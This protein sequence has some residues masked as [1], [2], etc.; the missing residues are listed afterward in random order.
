MDQIKIRVLTVN[1]VHPRR[2][3]YALLIVRRKKTVELWKQST[4]FR[5]MVFIVFRGFIVGCV[6]V[7]DSRP[8][9]RSDL[10]LAC[11]EE[12]PEAIGLFPNALVFESE[13]GVELKEPIPLEVQSRARLFSVELPVETLSDEM[14]SILRLP[15][16][17]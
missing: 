14:V 12:F 9:Q 1:Y 2:G 17:S 10:I 6:K 5:G 8:A 11:A 3:P 15:H 16:G 13:S 7:A 4:R